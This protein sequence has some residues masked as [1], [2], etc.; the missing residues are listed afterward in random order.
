MHQR[1]L[2]ISRMLLGADMTFD[3][4][5]LI[6]KLPHTNTPTPWHQ[7]QVRVQRSVCLWLMV[8]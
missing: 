2:A 5:M 6:S 8:C 3:F 7:D 1:A 4:D